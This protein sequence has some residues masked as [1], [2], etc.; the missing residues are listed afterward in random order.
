MIVVVP[1]VNVEP[2]VLYVVPYGTFSIEYALNVPQ[3]FSFL[4]SVTEYVFKTDVNTAV[5]NLSKTPNSVFIQP[6]SFILSN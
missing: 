2:L 6:L 5:N 4:V 3:S 1:Q